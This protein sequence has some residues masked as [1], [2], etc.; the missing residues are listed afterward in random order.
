MDLI[1]TLEQKHGKPIA[2]LADL[3]G[4]KHRVGQYPD[5]A[6]FNLVKGQTYR[7]DLQK[8]VLGDGARVSLPHPDVMAALQVGAKKNTGCL[9]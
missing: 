3:Q 1:R 7:F 9:F 8:G 4:P 5:G 2:I 6:K